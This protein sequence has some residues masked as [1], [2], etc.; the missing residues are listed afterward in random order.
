MLNR[1]TTVTIAAVFTFGRT[2]LSYR[3]AFHAGNHA[4]ML[5]HL[6][7]YF[8]LDYYKRKDKAYTY[9]DTHSGAGLYDLQAAFAQKVGEYKQGWE[10]LHQAPSLPQGLQAFVEHVQ[11][12]LENEQSYCG[13]PWLAA[14]LL[15]EQDKAKLF[16]LHPSDFD[17]LRGNIANLH[18]GRQIQLFKDNGYQGLIGLMPPPSRRGVVLIDPPYETAQDYRAVIDTLKAA[19]E[20]F[21]TGTYMLWYPL[22]SRRESIELSGHLQKLAPDNYLQAELWVHAPR[23]DG[24]GMHGSGMFVI[25]P[26]FVLAEQLQAALPVLTDTLAQDDSAHFVL[27]HQTA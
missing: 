26:P 16:E 14:S 27:Q 25:N 4:D 2:M 19:M 9:V 22:L 12:T 1:G 23:A 10:R 11:S 24:F 6:V 21:A 17:L 7:L 15:R 18:R 8:V 13:S 5:K 20:R 3:H